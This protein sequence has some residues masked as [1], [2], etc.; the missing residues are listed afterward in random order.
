MPVHHPS[1]RSN[2]RAEQYCDC[3]PLYHYNACQAKSDSLNSL[4]ASLERNSSSV[5]G[6]ILCSFFVT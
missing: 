6:P 1:L 3:P 5:Y 2:I 4:L